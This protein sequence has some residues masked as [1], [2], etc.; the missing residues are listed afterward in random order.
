MFFQDN[1]DFSVVCYSQ[2]AGVKQGYP[3]VRKSSFVEGKRKVNVEHSASP[4]LN[5]DG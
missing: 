5:K 1:S 4:M 3:A 2:E